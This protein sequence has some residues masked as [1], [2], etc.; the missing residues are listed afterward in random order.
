[1]SRAK[2]KLIFL[3][4]EWLLA[5]PDNNTPEDSRERQEGKDTP[6]ANDVSNGDNDEY[7]GAGPYQSGDPRGNGDDDPGSGWGWG[8]GWDDDWDPRPIGPDLP[9][10]LP[11]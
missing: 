11:D 9:E 2:V 1:M 7:R 5:K 8:W 6:E 4:V 3:I 10:S